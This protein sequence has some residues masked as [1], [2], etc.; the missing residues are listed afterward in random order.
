MAGALSRGDVAW[1]YVAQLMNLAGGLLLLPVL[2]W[3]WTPEEIGLW[4]VFLTMVS[5]AQ[6]LEL[7]VQP[8]LVRSAAYVYAGAT[9][10]R[11]QG[12]G[13]PVTAG[14]AV[15][16]ALLWQLFVAG[17]AAYRLVAA[18]VAVV[19]LVGGSA[20]VQHLQARDGA[21]LEGGVT[22]WIAYAAGYVIGAYFGYFNAFILGR[23]DV[24]QSYQLVVVTKGGFVVVAAGAVAAGAGLWGVGLAALLSSIASRWL[25]HRCYHRG[26]H[27]TRADDDGR[28][29][30]PILALLWPNSWRL[31]V[32]QLGAFLVVRA[33]T[34]VAATFLSLGAVGRYGVTVQLLW[35]LSGVAS[36]LVTLQMPRMTAAQVRG[37]QD[38][39]RRAFG[40]AVVAA[41]VL[42]MVGALVLAL[43]G[44]PIL[45]QLGKSLRLLDG[46]LLAVL[47]VVALLEMNHALAAT[48]LTTLNRIPFTAAAIVSGVAI[49]TLG[50]V[51]CG[52]FGADLWGLILA[53][54]LVQL[55]YNNWKWPLEAMRHLG[56]GPVGLVRAGLAEL[57]HVARGR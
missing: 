13:E 39:L 3:R 30:R 27:A 23:G 22:A 12:L 51:L 4:F 50:S 45:E 36:L 17:R 33:N 52:V 16:R 21:G 1:G 40:L 15:D 57:R 29:L 31:G 5:L 32:V 14:Q 35:V 49:V 44:N 46:A 37:D 34:L 53:Q 42:Y 48:Y 47:V 6:L 11:S 38:E 41:W 18:A 9:A 10:L 20:Y 56:T 55:C 43:A 8:T 28:P 24:A 26:P 2:L 19:L 25:A 7:A 54:G